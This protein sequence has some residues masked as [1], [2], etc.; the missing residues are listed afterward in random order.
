VRF[1]RRPR[2]GFDQRALFVWYDGVVR[3]SLG[4]ARSPRSPD[5]VALMPAARDFVQRHLAEGWIVVGVSWHPEV[6]SGAMTAAEVEAI[7][8]CT[9]E[10][11][12]AEI[13]AA[14]CPHAEGPPVCWCRKP[15]PGLGVALIERHRLDPA[16]CVYVGRDATDRAFARALGFAFQDAADTLGRT[17]NGLQ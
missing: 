5:D 6:A 17:P 16:R 3:R 7:F 1:E 4:G 13:E 12:G 10:L 9:H 15:L 8:A 11:L 2:P 14:W